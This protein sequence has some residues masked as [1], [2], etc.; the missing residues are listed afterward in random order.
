MMLVFNSSI[1]FVIYC[2][3]GERFR[4]SLMGSCCCFRSNTFNRANLSRNKNTDMS[5]LS[6]SSNRQNSFPIK[7]KLV[8]LLS[9]NTSSSDTSSSQ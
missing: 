4:N 1:N 5:F 9:S 3:M 6:S 2:F 7:Y 8:K